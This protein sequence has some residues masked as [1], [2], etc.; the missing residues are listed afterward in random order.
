MKKHGERCILYCKDNNENKCDLC[1]M[2]SQNNIFLYKIFRNITK[3]N[4]L[5]K[6]QIKINNIKNELKN[7]SNNNDLNL[8]FD[9]FENFYNTSNNLINYN[10]KNKNY[11]SLVNIKKIFEYSAKI[12]KDIDIIINDKK[13]K[14]D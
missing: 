8:V 2:K 7:I 9:N 14:I 10:I 3:V 13:K 12:I 1:D 6:L 4:N 11:Y 5:N